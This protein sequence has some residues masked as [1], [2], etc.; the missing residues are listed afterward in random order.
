MVSCMV[1]CSYTTKAQCTANG[2]MCICPMIYMPVCGC[3]GVMYNNSCLA[4]CQGVTHTPA[5]PSG[6]PG[7]YLPCS[8]FVPPVASTHCCNGS[9]YGSGVA[10]TSGTN[11]ISTCNYLT[12]WSPIS[13]VNSGSTYTIEVTGPNA[14]PGWIVVY[15]GGSQCANF[16]AEGPS[17]LQFTASSSGTHY[18]HWLVDSTC[19]TLTGCHTTTITYGAFMYGCT[20]PLAANYDSTATHDDGSCTFASCTSG[21]GANSESFEDST[22]QWYA[23]GPWAN[24][25]YDAASSTFAGTNGWRKDNLGT[26][27]SFTG[28]L[29]GAA[30]L[31]GDYYVYCEI[32]FSDFNKVANLHS[33]CVDLTNFTAPAFVFGYSMYGVDMGTLNV[34]VST[35]GGTTWI[36]EWTKTGNQGQPWKEGIVSLNTSYAGQI[37]Q[38]RMSYTAGGGYAADCAIDHL[39]F[40]EAPLSGCMDQWAV[41][42]DSLATIDDGSCLY[43]GC[44]DPYALNYC[45]SC[46]TDCDTIAGGTNLSCCIYPSCHVIP[47]AEDFESANFLTNGWVTL[48]N[49]ES[50][51]GLTL[52]QSITDTVS[53]EFSG[54]NTFWQGG[55]PYNEAAAFDSTTKLSHFASANICVDL[56]GP[57][58]PEL[59]FAVAMPGLYSS[60]YRWLRVMANGTV[61]ADHNGNTA[62]TNGSGITGNVGQL[63]SATGD[64]LT[65]D[66]TAYAGQSSV[67]ITFQSSCNYGPSNGTSADYVLVD[68][69]SIRNLGACTY[70]SS[71]A[72]ITDVLCNG[73]ST[74]TSSVMV[75]NGYGT[76]Y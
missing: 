76:E 67:N 7:G 38:V 19:A 54:G 12:E 73:D 34:D 16:I 20:N 75:S 74:G 65:F 63:I 2:N 11:T 27:T 15:D 36:N 56:A 25:V 42:Y 70:Y 59:T 60:P 69:I 43:P 46:N 64:T 17:P 68:N 13:S 44:S 51:V 45:S 4:D 32:S 10:P 47:F 35:D 48:S 8:T 30:S 28:P 53:L 58:S 71:S 37:I 33:S 14:N 39:R 40:M 9:Q 62:W 50:S 72:T 26:S 23:Q 61:I 52:T 55:T 18:V 1:L 24:W 29:N 31:D 6:V 66:L 5:T 3:D 22:V 21:I 57:T 41:N 49:T